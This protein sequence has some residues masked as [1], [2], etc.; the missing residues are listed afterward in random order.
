MSKELVI[1]MSQPGDA[2]VLQA[3]SIDLPPPGAGEVRV[4]HTAIGVNFA[5]IYHR[6]GLYRLPELPAVL[7]VEAAGEVEAIGSGP[8]GQ[9]CSDL[10]VGDR[11][12]Y[13]GLPAG[14]YATARNVALNRLIRIP[15]GVS[16]IQAAG[17]LL[18]GITAYMLFQHVARVR[19]GDTVLVQAAAGGLGQVLGQ[20]GAALGARMIGTVGSA[21]KGEVA[22]N[23][24]YQEA[25]LYRQMDFVAEAMR[26]TDGRG[27][28]FAVDGVGGETLSKTLQTVRP[29]GMAA[30]VGQAA[31][32]GNEDSAI[33]PLSELGP[34]RSIALARPSV[35]R[36]MSDLSRYREGAEAA[37]VRLEQGLVM[38]VS[39]TLPLAEAAEAHRQLESGKTAGGVILLPT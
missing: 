33:L 20:W 27:V 15:A 36:F 18:R 7:G 31:F 11:V 14:A 25:I 23:K 12:V 1:R 9:D 38:D 16:D 30:S 19:A 22:R 10:Q 39:L 3:A 13:T 34:Y 8:G 35:F 5:D 24:G 21:G 26:L 2:G 4:R 28:D 6:I 37:L 32:S 17:T 29:F